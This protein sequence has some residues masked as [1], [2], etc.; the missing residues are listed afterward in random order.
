MKRLMVSAVLEDGRVV[1]L[2]VATDEPNLWNETLTEEAMLGMIPGMIG[3]PITQYKGESVVGKVSRAWV[4]D[5][6]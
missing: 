1:E 3:K 5:V 6:P 4:E 2:P